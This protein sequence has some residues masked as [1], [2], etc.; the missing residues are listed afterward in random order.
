MDT[1]TA[2]AAIAFLLVP[3]LPTVASAEGGIKVFHNPKVGGKRLDGC[4]SWPGPCNSDDAA[5]AF[6]NMKGY[7]YASDFKTSNVVGL[8]QTKRLGDGGTCTASCTV[9]LSVTCVPAVED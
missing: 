8:Y 2:L 5:S 7:G 9:M 6:C 4:Y 3:F 1:R